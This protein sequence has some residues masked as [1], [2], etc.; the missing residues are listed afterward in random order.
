[1]GFQEQTIHVLFAK[2]PKPL[3]HQT[4]PDVSSMK[5]LFQTS[6]SACRFSLV[7]D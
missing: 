2:L 6:G 5:P 3:S 1:M 7:I 4:R